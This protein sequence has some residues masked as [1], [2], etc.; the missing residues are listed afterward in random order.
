MENSRP[1]RV[2]LD[3]FILQEVLYAYNNPSTVKSEHEWVDWVFRLRRPDQRHALEFVEGWNGYRIGIIGSAPWIASSI[4]GII[5]S[6]MG[7]DMVTAF[8]VAIFILT[9]GTCKS[10]SRTTQCGLPFCAKEW[11]QLTVVF[12]QL[13]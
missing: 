10:P 1:T 12:L 8:T 2:P 11:N 13:G 3:E 7:G 5:W 4:V 6:A 9:V